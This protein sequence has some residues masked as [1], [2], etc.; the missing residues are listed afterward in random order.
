M[1][2]FCWMHSKEN[3][4]VTMFIAYSV[5]SFIIRILLYLLYD[6]G[7]IDRGAHWLDVVVR[8]CPQLVLSMY[9]YVFGLCFFRPLFQVVY[10]LKDS[11]KYSLLFFVT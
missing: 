6:I 11:A 3:I 4:L 8:S 2:V 7:F 9:A 10:C 1:R 5:F